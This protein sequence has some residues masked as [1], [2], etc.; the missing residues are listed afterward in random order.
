MAIEGARVP[1]DDELEGAAER[2]LDDVQRDAER[3]Y[4]EE[5]IRAVEAGTYD[6]RTVGPFDPEKHG[7]E[8]DDENDIYD[9]TDE[10]SDG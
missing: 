1:D 7:V 9:P 10:F 6:P 8:D 2:L 5:A 4:D 3:Y